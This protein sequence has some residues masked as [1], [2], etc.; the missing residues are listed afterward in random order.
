MTKEKEH[1]WE[2]DLRH[3]SN[4][5]GQIIARNPLSKTKS[6]RLWHLTPTNALRALGLVFETPK[7]NRMQWEVDWTHPSNQGSVKIM[8]RNPASHMPRARDW[9]MTT[10]GELRRAGFNTPTF[11]ADSWE[12]DWTKR[13]EKQV[14]ARNP[15]SKMP[16]AREWH[17]IDMT[18]ILRVGMKWQPKTEASING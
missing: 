10:M 13:N 1:G 12:V 3:P 17:W 5:P 18:T 9:H 16:S 15:W 6:A 11:R 8:A 4:T 2:I 7:N 14:W